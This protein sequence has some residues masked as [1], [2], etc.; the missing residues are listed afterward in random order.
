[1]PTLDVNI[2]IRFHSDF[3]SLSKISIT[4][5][6]NFKFIF[7]QET[8]LLIDWYLLKRF[9]TSYIKQLL[10]INRFV[11]RNSYLSENLVKRINTLNN[12]KKVRP[13]EVKKSLAVFYCISPFFIDESPKVRIV[14]I[15]RD[16]MKFCF[17]IQRIRNIRLFEFAANRRN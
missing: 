1:M 16:K 9:K 2:T 14:N 7:F 11:L 5:L 3:C 15:C 17:F 4:K 10:A 8:L 12:K 6:S 13:D